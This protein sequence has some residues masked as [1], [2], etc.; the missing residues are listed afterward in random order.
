MLCSLADDLRRCVEGD[1]VTYDPNNLV[2]LASSATPLPFCTLPSTIPRKCLL[3]GGGSPWGSC[4][5]VSLF[6]C[7]PAGQRVRNVG[8]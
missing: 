2:N 4:A 6:R 3:R 7:E 5:E 8:L 1:D